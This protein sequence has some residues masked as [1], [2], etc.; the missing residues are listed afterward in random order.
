MP[1]PHEEWLSALCPLSPAMAAGLP[2][3]QGDVHVCVNRNATHGGL[4]IAPRFLS[5][6][7]TLH[8]TE[9][10]ERNFGLIN[11]GLA[12]SRPIW[13]NSTNVRVPTRRTKGWSG[14]QTLAAVGDRLSAFP[15]SVPGSRRGRRETIQV[16]VTGGRGTKPRLGVHHDRNLGQHR[17]LTVLGYLGR[18]TPLGAHTIFP[19]FDAPM[20]AGR[21]AQTRAH[22][23][24]PLAE[25]ALQKIRATIRST[26]PHERSMLGRNHVLP[27]VQVLCD[28]TLRA[29]RA[30]VAPPCLAVPPVPGSAAIF[31]HYGDG[32]GGSMVPEWSNFHIA[33]TTGE[34][35]PRL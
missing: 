12:D 29:A 1:L 28:A 16:A 26:P 2:F 20:T 13:Y 6:V 9:R 22:P 34:G 33:C 18:S 31:W 3:V 27:E 10:L 7:E 11:R 23:W 4:F 21:S 32:G 19:L 15:G 17:V 14:P 8:F 25:A 35:G 24:D 30:G 5:S